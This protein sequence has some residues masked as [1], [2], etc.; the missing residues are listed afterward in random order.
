VEDKFVETFLETDSTGNS[1][2][3]KTTKVEKAVVKGYKAVENGVV[4]GYKAVEKAVVDGYKNTE[5]D[6]KQTI[7][8]KE[9]KNRQEIMLQRA[10]ISIT[11]AWVEI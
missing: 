10:V 9:E 6:F 11:R 3:L 8:N 7:L 4:N 1:P 2:K 5:E